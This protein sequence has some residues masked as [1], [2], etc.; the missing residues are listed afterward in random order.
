MVERLTSC[1]I[2]VNPIRKGSAASIINKVGDYAMAGL[3]VVNSQES[4]EYRNLIDEYHMGLNC[5]NEDSVDMKEKL[6]RLVL[7][8]QLRFE[9]GRNARKCAEEKFDRKISYKKIIELIESNK[10]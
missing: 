9:M 2:A 1:D 3:P 4:L 10:G 6:E 5:N 8:E 7:D